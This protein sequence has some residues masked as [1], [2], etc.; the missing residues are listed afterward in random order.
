MNQKKVKLH[1]KL[2]KT[3]ESD[4]ISKEYKRIN[5]RVKEMRNPITNELIY[6]YK[7]YTI[8]NR[9]KKVYRDSKKALG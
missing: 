6:T 9:Y 1:R 2:F 5:E 8:I 4:N 7:T 3:L